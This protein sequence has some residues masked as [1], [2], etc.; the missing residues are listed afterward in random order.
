M[1]TYK[2]FVG[3]TDYDDNAEVFFGAVV[4][5]TIILSFRGSSVEDLKASFR[6]VVDTYLDDCE[7]EGQ[8]P[9]K[10]F[11]GK[12]TLRVSPLLH[13]RLALKAAAQR[14][15]MKQYMEDLIERDTLD[16]QVVG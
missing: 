12:I 1:L 11:S 10:P 7:R 3:S 6:D 8:D 9:E 5:A 4:N 15:A 13:K 16:V 2:G 14:E